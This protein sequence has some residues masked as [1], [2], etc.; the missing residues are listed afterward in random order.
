MATEQPEPTQFHP[1]WITG[2]LGKSV[3][4][5]YWDARKVST[6]NLGSLLPLQE[7]CHQPYLQ[8]PLWGAFWKYTDP[9]T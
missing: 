2:M 7:L 1:P 8:T 4:L 5:D 3:L 6:L 9:Y